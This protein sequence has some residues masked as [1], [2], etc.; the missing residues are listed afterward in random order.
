MACGCD[1]H[2][3]VFEGKIAETWRISGS[4]HRHS[5]A[6][7]KKNP[8]SNLQTIIH[9]HSCQHISIG[10]FRVV[11]GS[12]FCSPRRYLEGAGLY[13]NPLCSIEKLGRFWMEINPTAGQNWWSVNYFSALVSSLAGLAGALA[14]FPRTTQPLSITH[15]RAAVG[16]RNSL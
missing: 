1:I 7:Q 10:A 12:A 14:C 5:S 8:F 6:I 15:R 11:N 13:C 2:T 9:S 3:A 4:V 16:F